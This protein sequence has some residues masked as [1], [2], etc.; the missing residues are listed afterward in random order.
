M[1][2]AWGTLTG[3]GGDFGVEGYVFS[4]ASVEKS[5]SG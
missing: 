3:C 4:E 5:M 2:E 1:M